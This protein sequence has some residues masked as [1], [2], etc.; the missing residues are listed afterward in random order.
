VSA[1]ELEALLLRMDGISDTAVMGVAHEA[2]GE[3]PLAFVVTRDGVRLSE[4][5]V[6]GFVEAKAAKHKW[7]A[8]G[9]VFLQQIPRSPAGKILKKE[10]RMLLP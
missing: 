5:D 1:S 9:V 7:L 10:L 4:A 2:L 6:R 8:G 3:A